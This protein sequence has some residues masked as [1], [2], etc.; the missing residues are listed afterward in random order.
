M[1]VRGVAAAVLLTGCTVVATAPPA[2]PPPAAPAPAGA[3]LSWEPSTDRPGSDYRNFD[4]RLPQDCREACARDPRCRAFTDRGGRCWL[5]EAVPNGIADGCC[6]SGA[7]GLG[8]DVPPPPPP[9]MTELSW[10]PGTDRPGSDY[11][12]FN[13]AGPEVCREACTPDP[14]CRAFSFR[15][16]ICWLKQSIPGKV[17]D[18][19][20]LSGARASYQ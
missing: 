3:G 16:G 5:K 1:I 11:R 6:V 2:G 7:K 4:V 14:R 17:R 20:C 13:A 10:E 19:C 9:P 18:N 15:G 8:P 12:H